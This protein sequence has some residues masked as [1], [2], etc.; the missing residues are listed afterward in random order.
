MNWSHEDPLAPSRG[1]VNGLI[2]AALF[3]LTVAI[4]VTRT[5]IDPHECAVWAIAIGA[6]LA[7]LALLLW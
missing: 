5:R 2:L 3:W 4:A 1:C 7:G 6:G